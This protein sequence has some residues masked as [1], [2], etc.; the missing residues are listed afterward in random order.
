MLR[1]FLPVILVTSVLLFS[2]KKSDTV[3][4]NNSGTNS[5]NTSGV[6]YNVNKT[7]LLQLV[8]DVRTKGCTCG[9]TAMPAVAQLVWNDQLAKAGYD[10]SVDMKTNN[11]FS[12]TGLN[13]STVGQRITAAGYIWK[14][15]GENIANGFANEQDVM[16][17]WLSSEGHCKNIMDT[18]FKDI[19]VGHDGSYWTQE[20]G[21]K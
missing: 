18:R 15:A 17:G 7:T 11:Y 3:A 21:S 6:V 10:H 19:G 20:F 9:T 1:R 14:F 12:H 5:N 4:D 16:N 13:G 8:N 2:C